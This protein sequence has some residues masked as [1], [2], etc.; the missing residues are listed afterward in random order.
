MGRKIIFSQKGVRREW[1]TN[2]RAISAAKAR[3]NGRLFL[4]RKGSTNTPT[5]R[6]VATEMNTVVMESISVETTPSSSP[7]S[8]R[9]AAR[10]RRVPTYVYMHVYMVYAYGRA[11]VWFCE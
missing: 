6:A 7:Y 9:S 11:C 4:P 8:I 2:R 5:H 10:S 1:L 3:G